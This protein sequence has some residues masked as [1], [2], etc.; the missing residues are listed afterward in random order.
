MLHILYHGLAPSFIDDIEKGYVLRTGRRAD[1][2]VGFYGIPILQY[3]C[4]APV[5]FSRLALAVAGYLG[6]CLDCHLPY[7]GKSW[8]GSEAERTREL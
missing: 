7:P 5:G 4:A 3:K 6:T 8:A 1:K 2:Q